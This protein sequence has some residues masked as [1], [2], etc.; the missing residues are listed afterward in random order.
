[1]AKDLSGNRCHW[2]KTGKIAEGNATTS[3]AAAWLGLCSRCYKNPEANAARR[4]VVGFKPRADGR[5]RKPNDT[6]PPAGP[7][8]AGGEDRKSVV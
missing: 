7:T 8:P 1:M 4:K 5:G 2:C 6:V 3:K